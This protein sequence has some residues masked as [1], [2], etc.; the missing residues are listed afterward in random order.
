MS[1]DELDDKEQ[2]PSLVEVKDV[3]PRETQVEPVADEVH[4]DLVGF[5]QAQSP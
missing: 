1:R 5:T 3:G 2:D 4:E